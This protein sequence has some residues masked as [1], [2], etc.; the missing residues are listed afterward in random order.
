MQRHSSRASKRWTNQTF[1]SKMTLFFEEIKTISNLTN[2]VENPTNFSKLG[3]KFNRE[4]QRIVHISRKWIFSA[5]WSRRRTTLSR[6]LSSW[7]IQNKRAW[8]AFS[9][10]NQFEEYFCVF[11]QS[12]QGSQRPCDHLIQAIFLFIRSNFKWTPLNAN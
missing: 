6:L 1:K 11:S 5:A 2:F 8:V 10:S 12:T 9:R 7:H 4:I 3:P